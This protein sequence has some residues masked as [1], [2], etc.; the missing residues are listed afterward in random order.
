[1]LLAFLEPIERVEG[2]PRLGRLTV[3]FE[4]QPTTSQADGSVTIPWTSPQAGTPDLVVRYPGTR[5]R[6]G[7]ED[8]ARAFVRPART[9]LLVVDI[10][11]VLGPQPPAAWE[12]R[13]I[14]DIP[15]RPGASKA[16]QEAAGRGY[17]VVYLAVTAPSPLVYRKYRDWVLNQSGGDQPFPAGPVLGKTSH[18]QEEGAAREAQFRDLKERFKGPVVALVGTGTAAAVSRAVGVRT[19][20]LGKDDAPQEVVRL[21]SIEKLGSHLTEV[22]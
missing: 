21:P 9:P 22:K 12:K 15:A 20:L 1:M 8:R 6:R 5:K 19:L 4:N 3:E 11:S 18:A 16:L 17:Q 13:N 14:L 10:A 7:A 2:K